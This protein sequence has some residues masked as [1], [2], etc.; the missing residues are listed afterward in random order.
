MNISNESTYECYQD[1]TFGI[2]FLVIAIFAIIRTR[3]YFDPFG[4]GR[5]ITTFYFLI[6]LTALT[7]SVWFL[8]PSF[9][10]EDSYVPKPVIAFKS[11]GWFGILISECLL[12][13]GSLLLYAVFILVITYWAYMLRKT[14]TPTNAST[15]RFQSYLSSTL[16]RKGAI[17]NFLFII[18]YILLLEL[19]NILLFL[20]Q[21]INSEVMIIYDSILLSIVSICTLAGL[22]IYSSK[23]R[24]VMTAIGK[25]NKNP[26]ANSTMKKQIHRI[27]LITIGAT[28][29][30]FIRILVELG[31][32]LT[33]I[34]FMYGKSLN[35]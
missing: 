20:L 6:V 19:F 17:K 22:I 10:L 8:I 11:N 33:V 12:V 14:S 27:W 9:V 21:Y 13:L 32:A 15:H 4:A 7:R 16:S 26:I 2:A 25:L 29:F 5:V 31:F 18:S 35:H 30:F 3:L 34:K 28:L 24:S 1:L 23:I